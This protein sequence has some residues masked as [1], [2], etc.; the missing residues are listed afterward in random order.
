[1]LGVR[2][3]DAA[4]NSRTAELFTL[5]NRLEDAVHLGRGNLAGL[6]QRLNHC[7]EDLLFAVSR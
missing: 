1:M 7:P 6:D 3:R 2:N 4:A 5:E